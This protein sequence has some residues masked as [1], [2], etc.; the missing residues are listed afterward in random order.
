MAISNAHA[1]K[2]NKMNRASQNVDLGTVIQDLQSG[3]A[4]L[5]AMVGFSGSKTVIDAE[6][7]GSRVPIVPGVSSIRGYIVQAYRSGSAISQTLKVV[8]GSVAGTLVVSG[9]LLLPGCGPKDGDV[10]EY[11][12]WTY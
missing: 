4:T 8:S 5:N 3:S 10:I 2:I 6:A 11:M 7:N 1:A 12:G 9:S